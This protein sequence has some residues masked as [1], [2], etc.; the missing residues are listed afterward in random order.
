MGQKLYSKRCIPCE[1]GTEPLSL[2]KSRELLEQINGW[3]LEKNKLI[4]N[5]EKQGKY[6]VEKIKSLNSKNVKEIRG[7]GLMIGIEI[8]GNAKEVVSQCNNMGLLINSPEEKVL[9]LLP[10]L[11][12]NKK[13]I[14]D[15]IKIL[16]KTIN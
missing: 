4:E 11:I 3:V 15:S 1:G 7:K 5:A 6:I 8:E 12:I 2:A 9:R 13:I 14:D 16:R 10:P